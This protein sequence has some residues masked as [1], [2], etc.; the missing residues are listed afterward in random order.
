MNDRRRITFTPS[1]LGV[2]QHSL[3]TRID[4]LL[5]RVAKAR[6]RATRNIH[7]AECAHAIAA[8]RKTYAYPSGKGITGQIADRQA[9]RLVNTLARWEEHHAR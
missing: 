6:E 2:V 5:F 4:V 9:Q 8:Y 1:E 3:S 7:A